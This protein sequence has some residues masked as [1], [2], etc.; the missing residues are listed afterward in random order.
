MIHQVIPSEAVEAAA[1][2][3]QEMR[4][5][6]DA[7]QKELLQPHHMDLNRRSSMSHFDAYHA[8]YADECPICNARTGNENEGIKK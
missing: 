2:V 5:K 4:A 1:F 3:K 8:E 7:D 6:F